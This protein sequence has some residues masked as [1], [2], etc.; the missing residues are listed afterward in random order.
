MPKSGLKHAHTINIVKCTSIYMSLSDL[1][2]AVYCRLFSIAQ[3]T[4]IPPIYITIIQKIVVPICITRLDPDDRVVIHF[5]P[6]ESSSLCFTCSL[7][8]CIT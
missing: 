7:S 2:T 3:T 6:N 1:Y 5:Q 8:Y 4:L